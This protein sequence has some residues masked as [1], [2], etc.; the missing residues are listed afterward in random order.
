MTFPIVFPD[1]TARTRKT[2][3]NTSH[4]AGDV[5]QGIVAAS[6]AVVYRILTDAGRP[7][8]DEEIA[9]EADWYATYS[10][11]RLRT[12]RHELVELGR[13]V[14]VGT[15]TP[16]GHRTRMTLWTVAS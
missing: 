3:P 1:D 6:R 11:S 14:A 9:D 4:E 2:D 5:T 7:L 15:V 12:A 16:E 13:V 10:P 8:T